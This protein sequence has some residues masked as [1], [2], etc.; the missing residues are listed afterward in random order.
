VVLDRENGGVDTGFGDGGAAEHLWAAAVVVVGDHDSGAALGDAF[1]FD[2]LERRVP[3]GRQCVPELDPLI[4]HV[5]GGLALRHG[6]THHHEIPWLRI[7][8]A[9]RPMRSINSINS[10]A[11]STTSPVNS[12]RT[13]RR[14]RMASHSDLHPPAQSPSSDPG[15]AGRAPT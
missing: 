8:D 12:A 4:R 2:R 3:L 1:D 10:V 15:E 13:S 6:I 14:N 5:I 7:P 11:S 9:G